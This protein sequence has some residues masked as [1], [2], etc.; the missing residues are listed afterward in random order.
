M[1]FVFNQE[2]DKLVFLNNNKKIAILLQTDFSRLIYNYFLTYKSLK[3][4]KY[5][6][7]RQV[8]SKWSLSNLK[9]NVRN[10]KKLNK[11]LIKYCI[12]QKSFKLKKPFFMFFAKFIFIF[13]H[14]KIHPTGHL[15]TS[16]A[17]TSL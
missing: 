5:S 17:L 13:S 4:M 10:F 14:L 2:S 11:Y 3:L 12:I 9:E 8:P 1:L 6:D 7:K 15:N 16:K